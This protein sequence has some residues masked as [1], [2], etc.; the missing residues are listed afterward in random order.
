MTDSIF[1]R[2][3]THPAPFRSLVRKFFKSTGLGSYSFRLAIG[4]VDRPHYGYLVYS[5]AKLARKLGLPKI[6]VVEFGV[7][8]GNGLLS[9]ERHAVEVERL[10]G[11]Q[12]EIYGFDTG[13]GLPPPQGYRD[14]PYHWREGFY[15]MDE[16]AIR[17][18]LTCAKVC[19]GNIEDTAGSFFA[20]YDPAP[21]GAISYDFDYYSS[22]V[23]ALKL[24]EAD[25]DRYLP[26]VFC[27]FDDTVGTETELL[28]EFTGERLAIQE[29]NDSHEY[30]KLS[31]PFYLIHRVRDY[32]HCQIWIAHFFKH[33]L[34]DAFVS[35]QNQQ[36]KLVTS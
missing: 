9:F 17:K 18:R 20:E 5:A 14:I 21:I 12:I 30:I 31:T 13:K 3:L 34:Y 4:A 2:A 6:S 1:A 29:F 22:T 23:P 7:A 25:P 15:A 11:V 8:G 33:K 10:T 28:S 32:W 36:A 24:L 16:V 19:L 35:E 26:R 27:Y